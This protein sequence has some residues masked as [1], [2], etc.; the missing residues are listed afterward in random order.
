[1]DFVTVSTPLPPLNL[2]HPKPKY[3]LYPTEII[4]VGDEVRTERLN[5]GMT[6]WGVDEL[7]STYRGFFNELE[8]GNRDNTIYVLHKAYS[9][10]GYIPKTLNIDE[11]TLRGQLYAHRIKNGLTL[12][13]IASEVGLDKTT[14]GRFERGKCCKPESLVK[15]NTYMAHRNFITPEG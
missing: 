3:Y 7:V 1:M 13:K 6:Q 2:K 10:L 9:F 5:R 15:I 12:S 14:L 8:V 11:T 4:A